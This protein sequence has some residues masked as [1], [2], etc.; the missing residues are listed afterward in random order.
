M[1]SMNS[2]MVARWSDG[3]PIPHRPGCEQPLQPT[4]LVRWLP[5]FLR[6]I[7]CFPSVVVWLMLHD[8]PTDKT[9]RG[10]HACWL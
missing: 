2:G 6:H 8:K 4:R 7:V 5:Y 10:P 1:L 9:R 3:P